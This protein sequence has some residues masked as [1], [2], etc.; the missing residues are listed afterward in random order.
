KVYKVVKALY[1][2]HQAPKA[3]SK[4]TYWDQ[5]PTNIA[6]AVICLTSNT[7]SE[8]P[9]EAQT[10]PSPAH[11]SEVP[12]EPQTDSSPTYTSEVPF[13]PQTDSSPAHISEVPIEPHTDLISC[14]H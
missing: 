1:G 7:P 10:T 3:C 12:F 9:S 2:L 8:R 6:T 14:S 5:I 4:S 13:E 11:T